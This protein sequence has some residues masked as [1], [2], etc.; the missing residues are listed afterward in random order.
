MMTET[1]LVIARSVIT[2]FSLIVF[3]RILGKSQISQMTFFEYVT[4]IT[5]G[6]IAGEL[7]TDL[8]IPPWP[9]YVGLMTWVGLTFATQFVSIKSRW[10]AKLIEGEPVVVIQNGQVLEGNLARLRMRVDD[11]MAQLRMQGT[12]DLSTVE[13]AIYEQPG[14]LSILK[15]SQERPVTPADLKISTDY[16]GIGTELIIDGEVLDQNLRRLHL[17]RDW[18]RAKL[19]AKGIKAVKEVFVAVIDSEGELYVDTYRD[20]V[21]QSNDVSDYPGPN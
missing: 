12:F 6:S 11:L 2:F 1:Y 13:F 3:C 14:E 8:H 17:N 5:I 4:G 10:V 18:L 19:L 16:E 21:P 9:M 15:R 20:Q 7:T